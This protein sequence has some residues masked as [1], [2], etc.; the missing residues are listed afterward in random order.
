MLLKDN[1]DTAGM[2]TINGSVILK[3]A[4]PPEDAPIVR[5]LT[6]AGALILG[7]ASMGQFA[8]GSYN[9]ID[10]QTLNPCHFERATGGYS[11]GSGAAVS[12]NFATLA[13]GTDTSTSV[14]GPAAFTGIVG[15]RPTT[16]LISRGGVAPKNLNFDS[17]GPMAR[18]VID[19]AILLKRAGRARLCRSAVGRGLCEVSGLRKAR[20]PVRRFHAAPKGGCAEGA[21]L[22]VLRDFFGGDPEIDQLAEGTREDARARRGASGRAARSRFPRLLRA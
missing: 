21:R 6:A 2:P 22:R 11:S 10:G 17:T 9:T 13:V 14:R 18:T 12:A 20:R 1:I 19:S 8:G 3:E 15:L 5:A 16:G 7:K 4:V